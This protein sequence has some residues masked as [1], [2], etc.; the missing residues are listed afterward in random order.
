MHWGSGPGKTLHLLKKTDE[1][2]IK[3]AVKPYKMKDW[4][5]LVKGF[6]LII[7]RLNI[8]QSTFQIGAYQFLK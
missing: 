4:S 2:I 6:E 5:V 1:F 8:S 7:V 3:E